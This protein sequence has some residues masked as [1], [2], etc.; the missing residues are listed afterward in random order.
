[1]RSWTAIGPTVLMV[2]VGMVSARSAPEP[3][4]VR[5]VDEKVLGAYAGVYRWGPNAFLYLQ[6]WNEFTGTN[7]LVA[8]DES[9]EVRTLCPTDH[10]RFFAGP[11][12]AD[13]TAVESSIEFQR[14]AAGRIISLTWCRDGAPPRVARRAESEKREDI[15]FSSGNVRLAGTLISPNTRGRHPAI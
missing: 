10:D 7:Q 5:S 13:P 4:A 3:P 2:L 15:H 6:L 9:G 12:A 8:F 1:M 11:A 14:D